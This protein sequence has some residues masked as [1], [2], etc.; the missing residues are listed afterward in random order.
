MFLKCYD[1]HVA[2]YMPDDL[3]AILILRFSL[4]LVYVSDNQKY[5]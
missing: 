5:A 1:D 3:V 4:F 2:V